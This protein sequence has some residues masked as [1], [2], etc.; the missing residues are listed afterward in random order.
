[1][2]YLFSKFIYLPLTE[3][4][5]NCTINYPLSHNNC[6][7]LRWY[8]WDLLVFCKQTPFQLGA[9]GTLNSNS[10]CKIYN[11]RNTNSDSK[12][13]HW[14]NSKSDGKIFYWL[15]TKSDSK[16]YLCLDSGLTVKYINLLKVFT[17]IPCNFEVS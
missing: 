15:N 14:L 2:N 17:R 13:Y 6:H 5:K 4:F 8:E 7:I 3:T 11:W 16:I 10:D 1:M 9:I 12:I